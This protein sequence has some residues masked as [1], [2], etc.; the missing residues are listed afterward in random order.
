MLTM[1][2]ELGGL[3]LTKQTLAISFVGPRTI[4]RINR[5]FLN[6]RGLTDVISFDYRKNETGSAYDDVAIEILVCPDVAESRTKKFNNRS[7]AYELVLYIVHG[8][9]HA[10]GEDDSTAKTRRKMRKREREIILKLKK[11][12]NFSVIFPTNVM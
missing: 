10:G 9:L 4:S 2:V 5:E 12:F 3:N 6:R 8:M 1:A 11:H 7:F